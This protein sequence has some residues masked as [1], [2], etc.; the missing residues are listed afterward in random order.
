MFKEI[1]LSKYTVY[2]KIKLAKI[3]DKYP[4]SSLSMNNFLKDNLKTLKEICKE[5]ESLNSF[6][7]YP[8]SDY[9]F[10]FGKGLFKISEKILQM[11]SWK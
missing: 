5:R 1:R 7:K 4:K 6:L 8:L 9:F 2:F 3:L 10:K 11:N